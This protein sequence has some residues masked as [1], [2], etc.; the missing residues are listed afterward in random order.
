[1]GLDRE[2]RFEDVVKTIQM[3]ERGGSYREVEDE[4]ALVFK[5]IR[6]NRPAKECLL[7]Q[8]IQQY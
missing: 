7:T 1:M 6:Y 8:G 2:R 4:L 5:D 3:V